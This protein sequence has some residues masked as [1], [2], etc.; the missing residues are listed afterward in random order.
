M[1]G[2][3]G[4]GKRSDSQGETGTVAGKVRRLLQLDVPIGDVEKLLPGG[5]AIVGEL[6]R[7]GRASSGFDRLLDQLHPG[8]GGGSASFS[9]VALEATA[10]QVF[11][12]GGS[13]LRAGNDMIQAQLRRAEPL[14]AVLATVVVAGEDV[15]AVEFDLLAGQA[16]EGQHAY[17]PR[18]RDLKTNGSNPVVISRL[19]LAPKGA[20]LRPIIEVVGNV[21]A[22]L[23]VHDLR[24]RPGRSIIFAQQ[25][26][27]AADTDHAQSGV[28]CV[29]QK[30]VAFE[31]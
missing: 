18:N 24:S 31:R 23:Y 5:V 4:A 29:K 20:D 1:R 17:D 21:S 30:D 26:E 27:S 28:V 6:D 8:L 13:A 10:N 11:P 12:G 2:G 7:Q 22:V 25:R 19:E 3:L 9:D 15:T 14:A 16:R